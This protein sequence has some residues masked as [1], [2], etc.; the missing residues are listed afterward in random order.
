MM[1]TEGEDH[2]NS[3]VWSAQT[4]SAWVVTPCGRRNS[5]WLVHK[6]SCCLCNWLMGNSSHY[7]SRPF[8]APLCFLLH[9]QQRRLPLSE[10]FGRA[11]KWVVAEKRTGLQDYRVAPIFLILTFHKCPGKSST[12]YQQV[13]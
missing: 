8:L 4:L 3:N 1:A 7:G 11:V 5:G 10:S 2:P 6:S 13:M 9:T 12:P